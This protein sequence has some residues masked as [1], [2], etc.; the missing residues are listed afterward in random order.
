[1]FFKVYVWEKLSRK[2]YVRCSNLV[3]IGELGL[4]FKE[5]TGILG[6]EKVKHS[7]RRF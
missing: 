6:L 2:S 4:G 7:E 3:G 5:D 1:M